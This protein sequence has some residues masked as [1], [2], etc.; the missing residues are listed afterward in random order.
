[1][2]ASLDEELAPVH[3]CGL[4]G[5]TAEV[6][7]KPAE[8]VDLKKR[9]AE[10][11][12]TDEDL[13]TLVSC[14]ELVLQMDA[15]LQEKNITLNKLRGL[16]YG[17]K[18][19]KKKNKHNG[20]GESSKRA[21]KR[22]SDHDPGKRR[23]RGR[24]GVDAYRT[25]NHVEVSHPELAPG[26]RCP[27]CSRGRL[28]SLKPVRKILLTGGAPI[29]ADCFYLEHLRC[30]G[31]QAVF[32]APDPKALSHGKY[33]P[34]AGSMVCLLKYGVSLP[35][36]RMDRLQSWLGV[37]L[38]ASSQFD[39]IE[40]VV[41]A[42]HP[43]YTALAR[44]A[45]DAE[46]FHSDDTLTRVLSLMKENR[47]IRPKRK[48]LYTTGIV[49]VKDDRR[50]MLFA[51]GRNHAGENLEAVLKKRGKG[52]PPPIHMADALPH[53]C[54]Y[55]H[56]THKAACLCHGRRQ[57][58]DLESTF[59]REVGYVL[60]KLGL[61]YD[62]DAQ[63]REQ[64]MTP[65]QRLALHQRWS[66]PQMD[67]LKMWLY[68][69]LEERRVEPNNA[70]GKAITYLLRHWTRLTLFLH[71]PGVPLDNNICERVIKKFVQLRKNS[72]FYK[73][74][75]GAYAGDV[76]L[77]LIHTCVEAGENPFDYLTALQVHKHAVARAPHQ[78]LPWNFRISL[79]KPQTNATAA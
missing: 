21:K 42:V 9:V 79:E 77:T 31:C 33:S 28:F 59:P 18:T 37:P 2:G 50:I 39:L 22:T 48:G 56:T 14:I 68:M 61:V 60:Y 52:L 12:L 7:V 58:Y 16:L 62:N 72:L 57:F 13:P 35:L 1:M 11:R 30:S 55:S 71:K 5:K 70:L 63:A 75:F 34:T 46:L 66:A 29:Q 25:A 47:E 38:P 45:A 6:S 19:E 65:Q 74:A 49:A 8:L 26:C 67:R 10:N 20:G 15:G 73:T 76:L 44:Q 24:L 53:N 54:D 4:M 17:S 69:L 64:N 23:G 41:N 32:T 78:W 40:S 3:R 36:N 27:L 51:T 43:A